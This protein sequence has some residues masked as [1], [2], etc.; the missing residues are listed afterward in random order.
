MHRLLPAMVLVV[1][2]A[3]G[4]AEPAQTTSTGLITPERLRDMVPTLEGWERGAITPQSTTTPETATSAS[5]TYTRG[6]ERLDLE[7]SD[8]GGTSKAIESLIAM[9]G[10]DIN[11]QLANGYFK[12]TT[13]SGAPAVESWNTQERLG[14]L[15][16]LIKQRYIIH[17][18]GRD[19]SDAAPMRALAERIDLTPFKLDSP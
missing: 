17:V 7:I 3:C 9:A 16:V 14:E 4:G 12:G 10:S 5:A 8:T 6:T 1:A 15:T 19:L 13:I 18:G 11:R 2:A